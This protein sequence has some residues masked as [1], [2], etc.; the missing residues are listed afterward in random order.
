MPSVVHILEVFGD[1]ACF[2]SPESKVERMSLPVPTPS[3][4]RG[5]LDSIYVK[6]PEFRWQVTQI[7]IFEPIRFIALRRN[8]VKE[9]ISV[10][11]VNAWMQ[12]KKNPEPILADADK[13]I[14][15]TDTKGRTQR[16]TMALQN[17]KYRIHARI[18]PWPEAGVRQA[19]LDEQFA[20]RARSGKCFCQPS[21][22]CREFPAYFRYIEADEP[23]VTPEPIDLDI[24]WMVYDVF[25]L[26]T[27]NR[28][29]CTGTLDKKSANYSRYI[30]QPAISFFYA[31]VKNGVLKIPDYSDSS[32]RKL[33]S[34][35]GEVTL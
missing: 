28:I 23:P 35:E 5:I 22:G 11:D 20:R 32:V 16:Q 13:N 34:L 2:S 10:L 8:E 4:A 33:T 19:S 30:G 14:T 27:S 1:F 15:G 3:V 26:S 31:V 24:G 25:D 18:V 29:L 17:V 21:F 7:E 12:G 6:P 9:K